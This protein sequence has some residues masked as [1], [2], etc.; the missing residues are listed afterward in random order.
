MMY[1]MNR[2]VFVGGAILLGCLVVAAGLGWK[3]PESI[4]AQRTPQGAAVAAGPLLR[5]AGAEDVGQPGGAATAQAA[6]VEDE[7]PHVRSFYDAVQQP[8]ANAFLPGR[9]NIAARIRAL[10][11]ESLMDSLLELRDPEW[12]C[13]PGPGGR[14]TDGTMQPTLP[15][16]PD[17]GLVQMDFVLS[18]R[19][20]L[21]VLE[22]VCGL[23]EEEAGVL[24]YTEIGFAL[25]EY[26][27][28]YEA[29]INQTVRAFDPDNLNKQTQEPTGVGVFFRMTN[30]ED[31]SPTILGARLRLFS[32]LVT[33]GSAPVTTAAPAVLA[34]CREALREREYFYASQDMDPL[35]RSTI[36][37]MASLYSRPVL[38]MALLGACMEPAEAQQL[39]QAL[40]IK[41]ETRTVT[42][43]DAAAT[44]FEDLTWD[45]SLPVDYSLGAF[46]ITY[47]SELND[48]Q[49]DA[50]M[51]AAEA[52]VQQRFGQ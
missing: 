30:N 20:L 34:V 44:P 17:A 29:Y 11:E 25:P 24:V 35:I 37:Q 19:R 45:G 48:A 5:A 27:S 26:R 33:A 23:P 15:P 28:L 14:Y 36:L 18:N 10:S 38:A 13:W 47:P 40:E 31:G 4:V 16:P 32:L 50:I 46:P 12:Y 41:W 39:A 3:W 42:T 7:T 9:R 43:Y 52:S 6:Y 2:R 51:A 8:V 49:F 22:E 21:K 1:N